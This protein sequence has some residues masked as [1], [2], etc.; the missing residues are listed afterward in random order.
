MQNPEGR[1]TKT[2]AMRITMFP[3]KTACLRIFAALPPSGVLLFCF[4]NPPFKENRTV[5]SSHTLFW[6]EPWALMCLK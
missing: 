1:R 6:A 2:A 5:D 4:G 3:G